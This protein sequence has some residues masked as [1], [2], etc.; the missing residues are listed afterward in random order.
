M[1]SHRYMLLALL[2]ALILTPFTA[3]AC[4]VEA[5]V[6]GVF[7]SEVESALTGHTDV[8][9]EILDAY[10]DAEL[11]TCAL[12]VGAVH[13]IDLADPHGTLR[14]QLS[15]DGIIRLEVFSGE[16]SPEWFFLDAL[17]GDDFPNT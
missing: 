4:T 14:E 3:S 5:R 6:L 1:S 13:G 2:V 9:I 10:G 7:S 12:D 11:P 15:R 8:E 17:P 16:G